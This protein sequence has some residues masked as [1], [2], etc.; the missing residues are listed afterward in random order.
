MWL[1][2]APVLLAGYSCGMGLMG[3]L[4]IAFSI[5]QKMMAPLVY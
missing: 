2:Y 5:L 4:A 1:K 3:M